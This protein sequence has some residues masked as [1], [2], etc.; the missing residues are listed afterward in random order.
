MVLK[1]PY[2]TVLT[3]AIVTSCKNG[4]TVLRFLLKQ[5]VGTSMNLIFIHV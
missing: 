5:F 2:S 4:A 1:I 3:T